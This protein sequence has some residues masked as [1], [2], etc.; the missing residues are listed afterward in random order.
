VDGATAVTWKQQSRQS[1]DGKRFAAEHPD[2]HKQYQTS[3]T[4][5]V[6]RLAGGSK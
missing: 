3:S 5:R 1:F 2:L 4:Y 6:L